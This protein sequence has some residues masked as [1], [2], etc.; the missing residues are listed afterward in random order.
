LDD[1]LRSNRRAI[2]CSGLNAFLR[3]FV[4]AKTSNRLRRP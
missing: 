1:G 4:H 3:Q 2:V